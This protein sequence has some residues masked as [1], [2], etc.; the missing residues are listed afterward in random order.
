VLSP[1]AAH[2]R[3]HASFAVSPVPQPSHATVP[4]PQMLRQVDELSV[5]AMHAS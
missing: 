1:F 3:K 2:A 4:A 5:F